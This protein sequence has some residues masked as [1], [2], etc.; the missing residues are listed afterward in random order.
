MH[1]IARERHTKQCVRPARKT[2]ESACDHEHI[3]H[4]QRV[5]NATTRDYR[6]RITDYTKQVLNKKFLNWY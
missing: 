3:T 6:K 1:D 5:D 4:E 2:R